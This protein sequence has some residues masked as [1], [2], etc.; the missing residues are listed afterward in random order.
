MSVLDA[1][2]AWLGSILIH[3]LLLLGVGL[4]LCRV[5]AVE[6]QPVDVSSVK[7]IEPEPA[8]EAVGKG[9]PREQQTEPVALPE[10]EPM[11][12]AVQSAE[13]PP[14]AQNT[15]SPVRIMPALSPT[16][17]TSPSIS[18]PAAPLPDL[19]ALAIGEGLDASIDSSGGGDGLFDAPPSARRTIRPV[20]PA[21][22]RRRGEEGRVVLEARVTVDGQVTDVKLVTSSGFDDL[23]ESA[24]LAVAKA[25]FNPA[26]LRSK[27]VDAR[28]RLTIIFRLQE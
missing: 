7:M 16:A 5:P 26:R 28:V 6:P 9:S 25:L 11:P 18:L 8:R 13:P 23:D 15:L 14:L 2:L 20:Y 24:R 1:M 22:A 19:P 3:L 10:P 21:G 4:W 17:T 12:V 27:V